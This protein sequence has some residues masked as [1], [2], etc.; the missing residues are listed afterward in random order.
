[1]ETRRIESLDEFLRLREPWDELADACEAPE[2]FHR[3]AFLASHVR[4]HRAEAALAIETSWRDGQLVGIAPFTRAHEHFRGLEA[5][6]LALLWSAVSPRGGWLV[7]ESADVDP[8]LDALFAR[9]D[10]DVLLAP[11]LRADLGSTARLQGALAERGIPHQ[12]APGFASPYLPI[13][14]TWSAHWDALP[15][16]RRR[17]LTKKCLNRLAREGGHAFERIATA[18]AFEAFVPEMYALSRKSW[19]AGVSSELRPHSPVAR[20]LVDFARHGL[21]RGLVRIDALRLRGQLI[22]FEYML[23][24]PERHSVVRSDYDL[25]HK[26]F[27][28]G[29]ALRLHIVRDLFETG[30]REYDLGGDPHPYKL[31]WC[32]RVRH[33]RTLTA[34]NRT[35]RG[36]AIL[37]A[38]NVL[39]PAWRRVR[40]QA[41]VATAAAPIPDEAGEGE[42]A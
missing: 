9:R 29:N 39:L 41:A 33:H 15:R 12:D 16:E 19:K 35:W 26:Y 40:G 28:P 31:E 38:K 6:S 18:E 37:L 30:A 24:G 7:R 23:V 13:S 42:A 25:D 4:A 32:D 1:M 2:V 22:A 27:T 17:Y 20:L 14:G 36:R 3:H 5:R 34:A 8:L 21:E 11:N 10:W